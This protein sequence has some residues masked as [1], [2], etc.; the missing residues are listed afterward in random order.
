MDKELELAIK[1]GDLNIIKVLMQEKDEKYK[2][3][4]AD[5]QEGINYVLERFKTYDPYFVNHIELGMILEMMLE[6]ARNTVDKG[7]LKVILEKARTYQSDTLVTALCKYAIKQKYNDLVKEI[8]E[9]KQKNPYAQINYQLVYGML[10]AALKHRNNEVKDLILNKMTKSDIQKAFN[11]VFARAAASGD[12]ELIRLLLPTSTSAL[13]NYLYP[14]AIAVN[15]VDLANAANEAIGE[16]A[17]NGQLDVVKLLLQDKRVDPTAKENQAIRNAA[18]NGHLD[19]VKLLLDDKRA[20]PSSQNN[21]AILEAAKNGHADVVDL[22]LQDNRV[23]VDKHKVF[24]VALQYGKS[25]VIKFFLQDREFARTINHK[26]AINYAV[27]NNDLEVVKILLEDDRLKLDVFVLAFHYKNAAVKELL[28]NDKTFNPYNNNIFCNAANNGQTDFVSFMIKD[29]RIDPTTQNSFAL[30][31]AA[32]NGSTGVVKLLLEDKRADPTANNNEAFFLALQ[33]DHYGVVKLFLEDKRV[34]PSTESLIF[35]TRNE[36]TDMVELL[37][38][39]KRVDPCVNNNEV[40]YDAVNRR[41]FSLVKLLLEDERVIRSLSKTLLWAENNNPRF[42]EL[43]CNSPIKVYGIPLNDLLKDVSNKDKI[44]E[45]KRYLENP[46]PYLEDRKFP[47]PTI[48]AVRIE[49]RKKCIEDYKQKIAQAEQNRERFDN[50]DDEARIGAVRDHYRKT[51]QPHFSKEFDSYGDTDMKKIE[52]IEYEMRSMF[53]DEIRQEAKGKGNDESAKAVIEYIDSLNP[54]DKK[55]L[56]QGNDEKVMEKVSKLFSDTASVAQTAW[57][58]YDKWASVGGEWPNLLT[59]P[60]TDPDKAVYTVTTVGLQAPSTQMASDLSREMMAY[61]YLLATDKNDGDEETRATRKTAFI[62]KIAEI[63]RAHNASSIGTDDPSCL[64]GTISRAGDMWIAHSKSIIPDAPKLMEEELRS[65]VI[66]KFSSSPEN[67]DD[68]Y[69]ALVMLSSYNLED[70]VSGKAKFSDELVNIRQ[71]FID[72]L[73]NEYQIMQML[74]DRLVGRGSRALSNDEYNAYV[75][76]LLADIGGPWMAPYL[77]AIY[78]KE[79]QLENPFVDVLELKGLPQQKVFMM[80]RKELQETDI[81]EKNTFIMKVA[82]LFSQGK[83]QEAYGALKEKAVPENTVESIERAVDGIEKDQL[84]IQK[85]AVEKRMKKAELWEELYQHYKNESIE[86]KAEIL[87]EIVDK[88]IDD[89]E[90]RNEVLK[91]YNLPPMH[92]PTSPTQPEHKSIAKRAVERIAEEAASQIVEEKPAV[93]PIVQ[94]KSAAPTVEEKVA[95]TEMH[96]SSEDVKRSNPLLLH[97]PMTPQ[98]KSPKGIK[99]EPEKETKNQTEK[100]DETHRIH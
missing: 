50:V 13:Y 43:C 97:Q 28:L 85:R 80:L 4:S 35:A 88:I 37:L 69:N 2:L 25:K 71:R 33:N 75:L 22:L 73:G 100:S 41:D 42:L 64:P 7:A 74:N 72:S 30:R 78:R 34:T 27:R 96:Q 3:T 18:K 46:I 98:T 55:K 90:D 52:G 83:T 8:I 36:R 66:G 60:L 11:N 67:K 99:N 77:T 94:Q 86:N 20:D 57:R 87:K 93:A 47:T 92:Q 51:I 23:K 6:D 24:N 89:K 14:P 56:L 82:N 65:I 70:V 91:E 54:E 29:E 5:I 61:S 76:A 15:D 32:R 84:E 45:L 16:A 19:V 1:K 58:A 59:P 10:A 48:S 68:L 17:R 31:S 63:R 81:N 26:D 62:A 40:L 44:R 9:P 53:L 95:T 39:D 21:E 49:Y 12:I 79:A 38:A